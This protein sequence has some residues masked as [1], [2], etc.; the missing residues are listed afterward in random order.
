MRRRKVKKPH[1]LEDTLIRSEECWKLA[2]EG[3][4]DGIWDWNVQT[5]E[6]FFSVRSKEMLGFQE[7][8]I[9]NSLYEWARRI[10]PD[11]TERVREEIQ[12]HFSRETPAYISEHRMKC[13]DGSY[14]WI[15]DRGK[16]MSWTDDGKPLRMVG[17]HTDVTEHK[18]ME[19]ALEESRKRY[20]AIFDQSPIAIELYDAEGRLE[21]ANKACLDMFGIVDQGQ[22]VG[23]KLFD[24]PNLTSEAKSQLL[25]GEPLRFEYDFSFDLVKNLNLYRT[26]KKGMR[27]LDVSISPLKIGS[28]ISGYLAQI[29]DITEQRLTEAALRQAKTNF[30]T[31]FNA[32]SDFLFALDMGG[33]IISVNDGIIDRLGYTREELVGKSVLTVIPVEKRDEAGKVVHDMLQGIQ[34][35]SSIPIMTKDGKQIPIE[36]KVARGTW[37]D[38]EVLF[39][40]SRDVSELKVSEEKFSKAFH[41]GAAMATL[42]TYEGGYFA[43]VNEVFL[44]TLGFSREEVIGKT[45][46]ELGIFADA[47]ER[48]DFRKKVPEKGMVKNIEIKTRAKDGR[49]V[50]GLVSASRICVQDT[51][52]LLT[53]INDITEQKHLE[54]SLNEQLRFLQTLID[55]IPSPVF[56]KDAKGRYLGC[57]KAFEGYHSVTQDALKG[58]TVGDFLSEHEDIAYRIDRELIEKGGSISYEALFH[59]S[60]GT[61]RN[62]VIN[63]AVYFSSDGTLGGIVGVIMDVTER[64]KAE[65]RLRRSEERYRTAIEHSNDGV[66][67]IQREKL[68]HVNQRF[69][70]MFGYD[71]KQEVLGKTME[72]II[73]PDDR[74]RV[75][76]IHRRR[77]EGES[78][79]SRYEFKGIKKN[80]EE[81]LIEVS[82]TMSTY[83][84]QPVLLAY[85][86]DVTDRRKAEEERVRGEKLQ[87]ALEMA[88]TICHELNQPLQVIIT[89]VEFLSMVYPLEIKT[90]KN[91]DTIKQQIQRMG[92]ITKQLMSIK[93]YA[94]HDY[95]GA[96][97]II[98]ISKGSEH[99]ME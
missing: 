32:V 87:S 28:G 84:D 64:K 26:T 82:A 31:F 9:G 60:D 4:G 65:I 74:Q 66:I 78:V 70:S 27:R 23:F 68:F 6:L 21:M 44:T 40:V 20:V 72:M 16:V 54:A 99:E 13:K 2:L 51:E 85:M 73:H 62:I 34:T 91:L 83:D 55:A 90:R 88:G 35:H 48:E 63:K 29:Q 52:Y 10:H 1:H 47:S 93:E 14:K 81:I 53:T 19:E 33:T 38:Q 41:T 50:V 18:I 36:T 61:L 30:S 95:I 71:T 89:N 39:G 42:T 25:N 58:K 56:Y 24:D 17:T 69:V 37:N 79:P 76:E 67:L 3:S 98:D 77:R 45:A 11:D 22:V 43:D 15:L 96:L 94:T 92:T 57:N 59:R 86:R 5:N 75:M 49:I 8:E 80:E 7:D 97:K 46:T 12:Q